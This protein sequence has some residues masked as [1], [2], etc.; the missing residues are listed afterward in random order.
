MWVFVVSLA[1]T[2][3][4][5]ANYYDIASGVRNYDGKIFAFNSLKGA[6]HLFHNNHSITLFELMGQLPT[7]VLPHKEINGSLTEAMKVAG[8]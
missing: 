8:K 1:I 6:K 2:Q 4:T 3:N 7:D 5:A